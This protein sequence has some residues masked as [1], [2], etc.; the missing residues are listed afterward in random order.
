MRVSWRR[1]GLLGGLGLTVLAAAVVGVGPSHAAVTPKKPPKEEPKPK[2]KPKKM[3]TAR[4]TM[5]DWA[6]SSPSCFVD[7]PEKESS[8]TVTYP[9]DGGGF[10]FTLGHVTFSGQVEKGLMHASAM[11]RYEFEPYDDCTWESHQA[12]AGPIAG[13]MI[14]T[15]RENPAKGETDCASPCTAAG[16]ID[17]D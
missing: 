5:A 15:Y 14:F 10:S 9:C 2:P 7:T 1:L 12:V 3:C 13:P 17:V 8:A 16:H 4:F 6:P 11:T